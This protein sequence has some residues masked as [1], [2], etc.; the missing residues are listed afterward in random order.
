MASVLRLDQ[1]QSLS[2]A[3]AFNVQSD[4][5]IQIANGLYLQSW[6]NS[7][8]PSSPQNGL[9]GY[10]SDEKRVEVYTANGWTILADNKPNGLTAAQAAVSATQLKIDYPNYPDGA[11]YYKIPGS[12]ETVQLY[13]D[14]TRD[15]GGWVV[16]SKWGGH[17]KNTDRIFNAADYNVNLLNTGDFESYGTY[18][19][20]SRTK[21]LAIW[22]N[23]KYVCRIHFRNTQSTS[24]SGVYFQG[25]LTN[26]QTFDV[27]Q[28]HYHPKYWS[29]GVLSSYQATGGGT[30]YDVCFANAITDPILGNYSGNSTAFNPTTNRIIGGSARSANMGYWDNVSVNAPNYGSFDVARH[31]GFFGDINQGNQWLFTGNP[32]ESRY[33]TQENKQTV[34]FLRW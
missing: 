34:I 13:T 9:I 32:N 20:L 10:N 23:S 27:W 15:G 12:T 2:G 14:M 6:T 28:G 26:V 31:M 11:Y 18:S 33:P 1:L 21:M 3:V 7:T 25:K 5:R 17:D 24:S 29:D 30:Y 4:G 8:R 22:Q 19:R 16:I